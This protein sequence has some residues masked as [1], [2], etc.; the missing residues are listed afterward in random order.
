MKTTIDSAEFRRA[1]GHF[2]TGVTVIAT[3][4]GDGQP[5]GITASSFVSLSL[6]PPL[7]QWSIKEQSFSLPIFAGAERF[8]VNLLATGQEDVSRTFCR[9]VDRFETV[10]WEEG[11]GGIPLILGC[12]AWVECTREHILE[13]GDHRIVVGRVVRARTFDRGPLLHWKGHYAQ[14]SCA[15]QT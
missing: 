12:L 6:D 3:L 2:P 11:E 4:D 1:M 14:L 10:E 5:Y 7:V 8:A 9:P 13:G 15:E